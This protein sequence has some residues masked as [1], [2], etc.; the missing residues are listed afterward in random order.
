MQC[1]EPCEEVGAEATQRDP[2]DAPVVGIGVACHQPRGLGPVDE[3]DR[4]V[5]TELEVFGDVTDRRA[6][7]CP[8]TPDGEEQLVLCGGEADRGCLLL[9]PMEESAQPIAKLEQAPVL[10]VTQC[11][12]WSST[13]DAPSQHIVTR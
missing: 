6:R 9:A 12:H 3:P 1:G 8:M 13:L 10:S 5:V 7:W 2:H 11:G 4:A